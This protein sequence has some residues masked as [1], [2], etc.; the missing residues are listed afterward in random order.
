MLGLPHWNLFLHCQSRYAL[1]SLLVNLGH[2]SQ[3][4]IPHPTNTAK[5]LRQM[6]LL[7]DAWINSD[8]DRLQ[9]KNF[10]RSYLTMITQGQPMVEPRNLFAFSS[11]RP[12]PASGSKASRGRME[13]AAHSHSSHADPTGTDVGLLLSQLT[14][15]CQRKLELAHEAKPIQPNLVEV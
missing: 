1:P 14:T 7:L 5:G 8:F 9:H 13:S 11:T 3:R 10:Y 12:S 15:R 2:G 4:L 6:T